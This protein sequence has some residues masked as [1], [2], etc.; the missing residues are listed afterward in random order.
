VRGAGVLAM[1]GGLVALVVGTPLAVPAIAAGFALARCGGNA[2]WLWRWTDATASGAMLG[3]ISVPLGLLAGWPYAIAGVGLSA[4]LPAGWSLLFARR[5]RRLLARLVEA[6]ETAYPL[7]PIVERIIALPRPVV[8]AAA[9]LLLTWE[10]YDLLERLGTFAMV[11]GYESAR[12]YYLAQARFAHGDLD[13]A[14]AI[15]QAAE[16]DALGATNLEQWTQLVA[17]IRIARG[18]AQGVLDELSRSCPVDDPVIADGRLLVIASAHASIGN[19]AAAK[20]LALDVA[21]RYG[22]RHLLKRLTKSRGPIARIA[23][24]VLAGSDP[25]R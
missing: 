11:P 6:Y 3:A 9:Q 13:G 7:E 14:W 4:A 21:R 17:R 23:S 20:E 18:D 15:A 2:T 25:Y 24:D 19:D 5:D 10:R 8:F 1:A 12:Q 16:R 22:G